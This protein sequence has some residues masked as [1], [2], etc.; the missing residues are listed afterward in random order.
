MMQIKLKNE[1]TA[2]VDVIGGDK[3][4]GGGIDDWLI[5][6][7]LATLRSVEPTMAH[8]D[9]GTRKFIYVACQMAEASQN[10]NFLKKNLLSS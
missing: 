10:N 8:M 5:L 6:V 9:A 7:I 4:L 3:L 1:G 2:G